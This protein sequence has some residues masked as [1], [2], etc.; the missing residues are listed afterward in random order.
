M[1]GQHADPVGKLQRQAAARRWSVETA[2]DWSEL[3]L[4]LLPSRIQSAMAHVYSHVLQAEM[5]GLDAAHRAHELAPTCSLREFGATQVADETRHVTF[6]RQIA[7]R[8]GA[9]VSNSATLS[10]LEDDLASVWDYDELILHAQILEVAA[11][12]LFIGTGK[13][14]LA[15]MSDALRLPGTRST[16]ILLEAIMKLVGGDEAR[17]VAFGMHVLKTRLPGHTPASR[18]RLELRARRYSRDVLDAL[19]EVHSSFEV[20]GLPVANLRDRIWTAERRRMAVLAF[21]IGPQ[22]LNNAP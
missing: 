17:H 14:G 18:R 21:D 16:A 7:E 3:K 19:L 5:F 22:P 20:L 2:L 1:D 6:F 8:L 15:L 4:G 13:H 9:N 10:A 11:Q 12:T